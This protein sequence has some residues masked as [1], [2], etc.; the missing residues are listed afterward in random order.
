MT[1]PLD[2]FKG[3][4]TWQQVAVVL[5]GGAAVIFVYEYEK[6]K[7]KAAAAAAATPAA[8]S[9]TA[10]T[11]TAGEIEDPT[12][13]QY[14]PDT[15]VDPA[16]G[17]T[18]QQEITEYG[19]VSAADQASNNISA[20][21]ALQ[22][23][24]PQEY[25]EQTG[26]YGTEPSAGTPVSTN[27]QWMS[28]VESGLSQQGYS[29]SDIGQGIAAYFA[30]KQLG[31]SADG[32][33]LYTMMNL[34]VSEFG[35]PPVGTYPLLNGSGGSS[36]PGTGNV[37]VPDVIGRTDLSTAEGIIQDAGLTATPAGDS[38]AGNKGSVTATSPAAGSAVA[39]GSNVTV[40]YTVPA[41]EASPGAGK[42]TVPDVTGK[43]AIAAESELIQA[44][45]KPDLTLNRAS[46]K[47]G[48][49]HIITKTSPPAGSSVARGSTVTLYYRDSSRA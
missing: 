2:S 29:A 46:D 30:G 32:T 3:L 39:R 27:A 25:V 41:G 10:V 4:K 1:N 20:Q 49:F 47:K 12:T 14:Y 8:A 34:A 15:S 37:I 22:G 43:D 21:G 42:V 16:T 18:Y 9:G 40:T 24:T 38:A 35:P 5:G 44:G 36:L 17:L 19:S 6:K 13:G 7:K 31:T 26:Q 23:V 45:L 28:E 33:S 11:G 48:I